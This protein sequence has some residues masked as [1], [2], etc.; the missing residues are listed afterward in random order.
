MRALDVEDEAGRRLA[1]DRL[2]ALVRGH[3]SG[4][5]GVSADGLTPDEIALALA[6]QGLSENEIVVMHKGESAPLA[7]TGD[8]VKEPQNRRVEIIMQ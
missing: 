1:Y 5:W 2:S 8:N 3:V 7:A 6:A 4:A